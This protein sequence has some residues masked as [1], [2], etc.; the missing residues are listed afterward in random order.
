MFMND[1]YVMEFLCLFF[2]T[3]VL[4]FLIKI[5]FVKRF[6][7]PMQDLYSISIQDTVISLSGI[8]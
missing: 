1:Y 3:V 8:L 4:S 6:H 2:C 7:T 5:L